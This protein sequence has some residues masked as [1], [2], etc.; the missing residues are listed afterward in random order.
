MTNLPPFWFWSPVV[1]IYWSD[2]LLTK[3]PEYVTESR[4][5]KVHTMGVKWSEFFVKDLM[6]PY[7]PDDVIIDLESSKDYPHLC[8]RCGKAA[9]VGLNI[10][11]C[12]QGCV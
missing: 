8:T 2:V 4:I 10:I 3:D 11:D 5:E 12:S 7:S 6:R 1:P 9:Y